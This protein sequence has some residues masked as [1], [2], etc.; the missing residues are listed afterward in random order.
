MVELPD[1]V[2]AEEYIM[3]YEDSYG[4]LA[5][6]TV[7]VAVDGNDVYFQNF[8]EYIP[9]AWVK[10]TKDGNV[11]TFPAMQY[12]GEYSGYESYA[13][14]DG[15]A[16]FT[17]DAESDT[18]TTEGEIYGVIGYKWYDDHYFNPVIN[19]V[20]DKAATPADPKF[21]DFL[22]TGSYPRVDYD[23]PVVDVNGNN[24]SASKLSYQFF[25]EKKG[26]VSPLVLTTDL[27]EELT[28]DMTVIPYT[29]CDEWDVYNYRLY[30]NQSEEE[31]YSWNKLGI[32][33]IYE[34]GGETNKSNIV[35][36]DVRE[37]W[38]A[39]GI[40][41]V[42]DANGDGVVDVAD[43]VAIVNNILEK[44]AENFNE[45]AADVNG[46][47]VVDAADVVLVVNIILDKGEVDAS[48]VRAV[49]KD[50]GFIF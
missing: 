9:E 18:Y 50:N 26:V 12:V 2:E 16:V 8:S 27:Y 21:T 43:V 6:K 47:N 30:L 31:L 5:A 49:L 32:Q 20:V 44:P 14:Y 37:Y 15:D 35:W 7:N 24:L 19:K 29:F 28:E 45:A 40:Y 36:Y 10:G 33:S 23:I 13:F 3:A 48:R 4:N 22:G 39:L 1:G 41:I 34:G 17:Y 46:D 11:V 42:G 38:T 25:I